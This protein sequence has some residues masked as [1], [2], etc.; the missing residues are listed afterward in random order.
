[1]KIASDV[2]EQVT[3]ARS[4]QDIIAALNQNFAVIEFETDGT[5]INANQNFLQGLGYT[6]DQIIGQHH[7]MF[8]FDDF[9]QESFNFWN[10][11]G[12]GQA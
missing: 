8:C 4:Q 5:I 12:G 3:Q 7:K 10:Q 9:Y 6:A 11:L 2:T 1:M